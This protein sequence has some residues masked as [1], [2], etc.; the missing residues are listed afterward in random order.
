MNSTICECKKNDPN[1]AL[2]RSFSECNTLCPGNPSENCG[3]S[4]TY[5]MYRTLYTGIRKYKQYKYIHSINIVFHN[6]K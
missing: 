3:G 6:T 1:I 5:N 4:V 2:K